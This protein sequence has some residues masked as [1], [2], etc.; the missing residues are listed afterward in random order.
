MAGILE[1]RWHGRGGQGTVTA[2]KVLAEAAM[3]EGKN[4]QAFPEYGPERMG[5]PLRAYN[6]VSEMPM[7]IHCQVTNPAVVAVVDPTLLDTV[8]VTEGTTDDA[9]FIINTPQTPRELRG[10]LKLSG[11]QKIFCV[12]ANGISIDTIGRIM[13]NTPMLGAVVK[14][15][16]VIK[17]A[18]LLEDIRASFGKK[19]SEKIIQ[20]NLDA[21]SRA[22]EEVKAE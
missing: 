19:F 17:L 18:T 9:V 8:D 12:D 22:Y 6:R 15:T 13:P 1:V 20:S 16:G 2:A 4:V 5:A 11:K 21:A 10:K 7:T 3:A 14:A